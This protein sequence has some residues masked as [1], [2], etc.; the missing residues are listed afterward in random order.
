MHKIQDSVEMYEYFKA[1]MYIYKNGE[2]GEKNIKILIVVIT[3]WQNYGKFYFIYEILHF[4]HKQSTLKYLSVR[5]EK[6][7]S[8]D[9]TYMQN[10]KNKTNKQNK[11]K[12]DSQIQRTDQLLPRGRGCGGGRNERGGWAGRSFQ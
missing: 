6:Q 11:T 4:F 7:I 2:K 1:P 10:L 3:Q 9:F 5:R 8:Y 12:P